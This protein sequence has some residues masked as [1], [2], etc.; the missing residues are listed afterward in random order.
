MNA[1][2]S[3]APAQTL[4][5]AGREAIN[6]SRLPLRAQLKTGKTQGRTPADANACAAASPAADPR[7][8]DYLKRS[9]GIGM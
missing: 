1:N 5:G 4:L 7:L 2:P 6:A 3:S 9:G 8:A